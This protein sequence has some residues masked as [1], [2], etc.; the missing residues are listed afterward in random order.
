VIAGLC[1][2]SL[3]QLERF[4]VE[5]FNRTPTSWAREVRCRLARKLVQEGWRGKEIANTLHYANESHLCREFKR[6]FGLPPRSF[7]VKQRGS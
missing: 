6:A 3:R 1:S 5:R 4:F 7:A 2:I